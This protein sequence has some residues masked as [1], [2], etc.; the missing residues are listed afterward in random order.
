M[1]NL[2][3]GLV[4]MLGLR[5]V[6]GEY[7]PGTRI[8]V[9][10]LEPEFGVSKTAI[11]EALR[12]IREKGLIDSWPKRGTI[13]NHR[14]AWKLLDGDVIRWRRSARRDDD[15]LLAELS[16]LRDMIEPAAARLAAQ[17]RE[18]ADIQAL[19]R[20]FAE[21]ET[22]GRDVERLAAA[23]QDFHLHLLRATHN[24]LMMRLDVVIVHALNA[25]NRIQHH[26]GA[27]WLDP[28][29]DHRRVLDAVEAGDPQAA[30]AAMK[31]AIR[32]SDVDL[33]GG[34]PAFTAPATDTS[35]NT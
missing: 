27:D 5:I 1:T 8:D 6:R 33:S 34:E 21:F 22:A 25:R 14:D 10:S 17:Y 19:K 4:D 2:H 13:V 20:S 15:R 3:S 31:F 35:I 18:P 16:Q 32:E 9:D 26:P 24:E 30:E 29:P 11:R 23:D 12:V 7:P 28:V